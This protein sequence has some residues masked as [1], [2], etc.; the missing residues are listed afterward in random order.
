MEPGEGKLRGG[1]FFHVRQG[2]LSFGLLEDRCA[3][4]DQ[5]LEELNY[6][7]KINWLP[8]KRINGPKWPKIDHIKVFS[9]FYW[10][11]QDSLLNENEF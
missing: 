1:D 11:F 9:I 4:S 10:L 6:C 3:V 5:F 7:K 2:D 8:K